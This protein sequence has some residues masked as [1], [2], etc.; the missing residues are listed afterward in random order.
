MIRA[1]KKQAKIS[2]REWFKFVKKG[3]LQ[4]FCASVVVFLVAL[5][6]S[7]GIAL[8]SGMPPIAGLVSGIIGG[9][10]VGSLSGSPLLVSGPAAGLII[11]VMNIHQEH[12]FAVLGLVVLM[13]G[14]LQ[15]VAGKLHWGQWFR[16]VSPAVV[17]GMLTGI[18]LLILANQ[19]HVMVDDPSQ[20]ENGLLQLL[21]IPLAVMKG[22][23]P[24][25]GT[26]HH[27]AAGIGVLTVGTLVLW[28]V[29]AK[30]AFRH[31]PAALVAVVA[32]T[33]VANAYQ[34]PISFIAPPQWQALPTPWQV[35][36]QAPQLLNARLWSDILGMV[37]IASAET[38]L[39]A[40]A[41]DQMS[42]KSKTHYDKE[43]SAQGVGNM[44]CGLFGLLPLTGVIVRSAA[45]V[46]AGANTRL[47]TILHGLW[48]L[49]F[50]AFLPGVL[51]LG[52]SEINY[53]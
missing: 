22:L 12:G 31:V 3:L 50:I 21:T 30:G 16:A 23:F 36:S 27:L 47:S 1:D 29:F 13:A 24:P 39:C 5:P 38:L 6:L 42:P 11:L 45:N 35:L 26:A 51:T 44:L 41:I 33:F 9:L 8:A 37:F 20:A 46:Q 48:M 25:E 43:L 2:I 15:I 28:R 18:G 19:F 34:L 14:L 10:V 4:D 52:T 53:L 17:E 40:T 32:G 7:M 49:A